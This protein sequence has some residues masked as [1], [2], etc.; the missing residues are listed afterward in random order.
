MAIETSLQDF[1]NKELKIENTIR[2][3]HFS[4]DITDWENDFETYNQA[5]N[6]LWCVIKSTKFLNIKAVNE[7]SFIIYYSSIQDK[8][9]TH[10]N[11]HL[12]SY[13]NFTISLIAVENGGN[14]MYVYEDENSDKSKKEAILKLECTAE[15]L[16]RIAS[17]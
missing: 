5:K 8:L 13:V 9:F 10:L 1:A 3:Y 16:N 11:T 6:Y 2:A 7:S 12:K 17:Y 15:I 4:Y 14:I